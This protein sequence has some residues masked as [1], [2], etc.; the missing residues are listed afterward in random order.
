MAFNPRF[1]GEVITKWLSNEPRKMELME[2]VVF[3]DNAGV[4]WTAPKGS[5]IDGASIPRVF[6]F[7]IGSPFNG[8]YRR[9][10]VV[11]DVYCVTKSRPHQE[12]HQMFYEAARVDGAGRVKASAMLSAIKL[13]GPKW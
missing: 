7:F 3:V 9:A 6:W 10:S 1:V 5:I 8:K 4:R 13:G 11:H 12:V 2:D